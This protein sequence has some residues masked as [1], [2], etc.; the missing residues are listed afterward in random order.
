MRTLLRSSFI[1]V[2]LIAACGG[3]K[4]PASAPAPTPTPTPAPT[5]APAPK[6]APPVAEG[7]TAE[8]ALAWVVKTIESGTKPTVAEVEAHFAPS[9]LAQVP[10]AQTADI[11]VELGKQLLPMKPLKAEGTAPLEL[12]VV[13][14]TAAGG[15]RASIEMTATP[16]RKIA[17]LLFAAATAEA[18]PRTY[19]DAVAQLEKAGSKTQLFVAE[20]VKGA[21]VARQNHHSTDRLAIGSAFK[22]W[23]LLGLDEKLRTGKKLSW[24][25]KLAVRDEAKSLPSGE[26]Q[27]LPA[28]IEWPLRDVALKMISI[29]DN[30]ATD[31]LIDFVGREQ[32]EKA[33]KLAKHGAPAA[34]TPFLR[35]RELFALK[36]AVTPDEL[37]GYRKVPVAAKRKLLESYRQRPIDVEKA[38]AD[39]KAPRLLDL[40]WFANGPDLCNVMAT[41]GARATW[42]PDSELL[43]ILG[44][45]PGLPYDKAQWS[46]VGFKGG[47]EPG[48]MNL[49]WLAQRRDGTWFV[50]VVTVNDDAK[51]VDEGL[52]I[53]AGAGT[54]A[55]LG[56]EATP[57]TPPKP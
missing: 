34:N 22:L 37:A 40:E 50:V 36:L 38:V 28:G 26:M 3:S 54:L 15:V 16:P 6:P 2:A 49:T 56:A 20:I 10:A 25:T 57:A 51:A 5:P 17:G 23:V 47:S 35:T 43:T 48:V 4:P 44:K 32:V 53:N 12:A 11:F 30:T 1:L 42:K 18:P 45:N 33:L 13:F 41:L 52:V 7:P 19:G 31:H 24:D 55:I 27:D 29:S 46:Y 21:C 9:F 14:D 39:W 8:E